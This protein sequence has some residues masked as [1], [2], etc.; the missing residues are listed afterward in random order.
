MS[1]SSSVQRA[2][3]ADACVVWAMS[4]SD[5]QDLRTRKG[6]VGGNRS[7]VVPD[8][9]TMRP[10]VC[11]V[12][13]LSPEIVS[14]FL[15]AVES[16]LAELTLA[17]RTVIVL[18]PWKEP[19][20]AGTRDDGPVRS[21]LCTPDMFREMIEGI[22]PGAHPDPSQLCFRLLHGILN[23]RIRVGR[24]LVRQLPDPRPPVATCDTRH[25]ATLIMAHRGSPL[26][27]SVALTSIR[28]A[29]EAGEIS[30][31]VGLDVD[32]LAPYRDIRDRFGAASYF[33]VEPKWSGLFVMRQGLL[34]RARQP[35]FCLQDSDDVSC[36]DRFVAQFGELHRSGSDVVG[37]HEL[38]VDEIKGTVEAFRL[39]LDPNEAL[40][41]GYSE[42]LLNG[43]I[44]GFREK[45]LAMGGYST[46]QRIAND[47]QFMLRAYFMLR[48]RNI[49][50]FYYVRRR[51]RSALTVAPDTAFGTPVRER[52]RNTWET[53]F[54]AVRHGHLSLAQSS[55][56]RLNTSIPYAIAP[57]E[58]P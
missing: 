47:T 5:I 38:R 56:R 27:L 29:D 32:D 16:F 43:T 12:A 31:F 24:L 26:H 13:V 18:V 45:V 17:R 49:D 39:P 57:W 37:C 14:P 28:D 25:P 48:M 41:A 33:H 54:D 34:E 42:S 19:P 35:L 9:M 11:A 2:S 58:E 46:D 3:S 44:V 50:G 22:E 6:N 7:S 23:Q 52:L 10:D 36:S 8:L 51:H 30:P 53:D 21:F 55:L 4:T 1:H 40:E 15:G 20:A